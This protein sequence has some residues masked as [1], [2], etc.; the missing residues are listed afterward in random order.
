ML[1][2]AEERVVICDK[3]NVFLTNNLD[4][5][6]A[7]AVRSFATIANNRVISSLTVPH[8]LPDQHNVQ[9]KHS[10]PL[11]TLQLVLS[12]LVHLMAVLYNLK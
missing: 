3:S 7:A 6:L 4:I 12:V 11:P 10:M 2:R 1:L 9:P 5:L 8:V